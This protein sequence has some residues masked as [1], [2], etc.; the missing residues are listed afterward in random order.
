MENAVR[1]APPNENVM[2][3]AWRFRLWGTGRLM[4]SQGKWIEV[5]EAGRLNTSAGP[6]FRDA[7]IRVDGDVL[8]GCVE[9][10]RYA[11]D[12]HRH[13][14]DSDPAYDNVILHVVG[15][16]DCRITDPSGNEILQTV[17]TVHAPF[18]GLFN[19]L[20]TSATYVL[21]MCG[22]H[23]DRVEGIFKTDWITALAFERLLRKSED[24]TRLLDSYS[25]DWFQTMF[26]T[27]A[28]GLG[29]GS[30]AD[31]MERTAR[32]VSFRKILRHWDNL[33]AVEAILIGQAGLLNEARPADYYEQNLVREYRFYAQ[34]YGLTPIEKP[35]WH[36]NARNMSNTPFRRLAMLARLIN[37][38]G[39]DLCFYLCTM[40]GIEQVRK[41]LDVTL[42]EYWTA[43]YGFGRTVS[44]R[45]SA[46]GKQS[47]DLL[48]INV[49]VPLIY[50]HGLTTSD[51][52]EMDSAVRLWEE[53][54]AEQNSITRGFKNYGIKVDNALTSQALIQLHRQYCERRRCPECRLGHRLLSSYVEFKV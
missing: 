18:P 36:L 54:D 40:T 30:N 48:M 8:A 49:L 2:Q 35:V 12:W 7:R 19:A 24:V 37:V 13:T 29:F 42:S 16:D 31:N 33:E 20:L 23:L 21:P 14:H 47:Q 44:S 45:M 41:F 52:G 4:T 6:D 27:L 39:T 28:R 46:L 9:I 38:Y 53:L 50:A 3:Q 17:M 51:T 32:S 1:I 11:S 10:H 43:H 25:G 15:N 26:V 5:L 22:R 34:K